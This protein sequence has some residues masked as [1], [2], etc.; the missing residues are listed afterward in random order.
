VR[1][2]DAVTFDFW[3]TLV[4]EGAAG[5]DRAIRWHAV[6]AERGLDVT[7]SQLA[8]AMEAGWKWFDRHWRAGEV[9]ST[10]AAVAAAVEHLPVDVPSEVVR[11]LAAVV[12]LGADPS[13]MRVAPHIGDCL[14]RLRSAGVRI[15]IICDVGMTPSTALRGYLD[16]H[17]LLR[18][19]DHWTFSD[20]VGWYKP[21]RRMFDHAAAGLG[22][23]AP[24]R[25]AHVGDLLRTD[26]A[27]AR[28][29]GWTSVRYRGLADD[30][31]DDAP[32]AD[33]V[34]GDHLD[35]AAL[36]GC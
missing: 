12:E 24:S 5:S 14:E 6:L 21:D 3:N 27:G 2:V 22:E 32:E 23:P 34:V 10:E 8:A 16:H 18:H 25:A 30:V 20:E 26:V 1:P 28:G 29:A 7:E 17:G 11:E 36:L 13:T 35:L 15:G 19:F 31:G 4:A 33:H 9:V